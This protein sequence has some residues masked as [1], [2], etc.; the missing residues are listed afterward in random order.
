[1]PE[2]DSM[3]EDLPAL[4]EPVTAIT[5]RSMSTCTLWKVST[6]DHMLNTVAIIPR[7]MQ[8]IDDVKHS[9]SSRCMLGVGE[10]NTFCFVPGCDLSCR[11]SPTGRF[12]LWRKPAVSLGDKAL[13]R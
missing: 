11:P 9:P 13:G 12:T 4:W 1:M 10:P 7:Q 2:I 8:R 5:G 6:I 3:S